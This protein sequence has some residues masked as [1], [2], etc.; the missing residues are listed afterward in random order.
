MRPNAK[1]GLMRIM[2]DCSTWLVT[3]DPNNERAAKHV[4]PA[5]INAFETDS[6]VPFSQFIDDSANK[7]HYSSSLVRNR[8][9]S[10]KLKRLLIFVAI[11]QEKECA[12]RSVR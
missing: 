12:T 1:D 11:L 9:N 6:L 3:I 4:A 5:L 10:Q 7:M 8:Q 2:I